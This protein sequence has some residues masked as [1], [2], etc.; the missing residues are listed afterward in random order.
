[1]KN[2]STSQRIADFGFNAD[3]S[4]AEEIKK[5]KEQ[6]EKLNSDISELK[7]LLLEHLLKKPKP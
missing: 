4:Q 2:S 1:M 3:R 6:F 7:S 5:L